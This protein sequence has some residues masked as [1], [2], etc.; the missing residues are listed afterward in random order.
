[1]TTKMTLKISL[2]L[3]QNKKILNLIFQILQIPKV[4]AQILEERRNH[5]RIRRITTS[6]SLT[7]D[8]AWRSLWRVLVLAIIMLTNIPKLWMQIK[9]L[10]MTAVAVLGLQSYLGHHLH[11]QL[12]QLWDTGEN[13]RLAEKHNFITMIDQ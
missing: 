7:M 6:K 1:M 10:T 11:W 5:H 2:L 13:T 12:L 3:N 4:M 9:F 8:T